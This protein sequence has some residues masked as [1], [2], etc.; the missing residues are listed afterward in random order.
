MT[1]EKNLSHLLTFYEY[2]KEIQYAIYTTNWTQENEQR[3]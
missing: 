1:W 3:I 2:P